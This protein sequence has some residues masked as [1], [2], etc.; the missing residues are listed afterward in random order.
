MSADRAA[1]CAYQR[2]PMSVTHQTLDANT[3]LK[4]LATSATVPETVGVDA[5]W[6]SAA[7]LD[8]ARKDGTG[9]GGATAAGAVAVDCTVEDETGD[10]EAWRDGAAWADG[11]AR[12][13]AT[14]DPESTRLH[15]KSAAS[16][17]AAA[18]RPKPSGRP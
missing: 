18:A 10:P 14:W 2:I 3:V 4:T 8:W 16:S 5:M 1:V 6:D 13:V 15:A 17:R 12:L 11:A 7:R 9:D